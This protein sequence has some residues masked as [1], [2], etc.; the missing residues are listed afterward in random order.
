MIKKKNYITPKG[1]A[2]LVD[3]RDHLV[4][5]ERPEVT[6]VVAWAASLGDRSENADYQYGKKRL[7]EIDRRVAFLNRR[8]N[9]A[10]VID[11]E[12]ISSEK[13]QFGATVN[14]IDEDEVERRYSIVGEDESHPKSGLISWKS[15]IGSRLLGKSVGDTVEIKAPSRE[16]EIEILTI[17]YCEIF[18]PKDSN[19][20]IS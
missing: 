7:R 11:P 19:E 2:R 17:E 9:E 14:V 18:L 1:Y 8:I 12:S 20:N 16:F 5:T 15:P 10:Q 13:V 4:K 6:K 3:E